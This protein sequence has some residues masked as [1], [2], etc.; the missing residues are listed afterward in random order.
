MPRLMGGVTGARRFHGLR[1]ADFLRGRCFRVCGDSSL[2]GRQRPPGAAVAVR[3][4]FPNTR[5]DGW[6]GVTTF[7]A[8][9]ISVGFLSA[10]D[11]RTRNLLR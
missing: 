6:C 3:V 10:D 7:D 11:F 9:T 8:M 2:G 5:S 4:S 1:R